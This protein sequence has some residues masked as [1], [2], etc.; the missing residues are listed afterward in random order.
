[1]KSEIPKGLPPRV[2][3]FAEGSRVPIVVQSGLSYRYDDRRMK[4]FRRRYGSFFMKSVAY[5]TDGS[6]RLLL[7][8]DSVSGEWTPPGGFV[9]PNESFEEAAIREIR[10]ETGLSAE[11]VRARR[12][13][14]MIYDSPSSGRVPV[15][16]AVFRG[17]LTRHGKVSPG[18]TEVSQI[19]YFERSQIELLVKEGKAGAYILEDW[20]V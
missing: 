15:Y 18:S 7:V 1:M 13:I 19:S 20:K 6:H 14:T 11:S 3:T 4:S 5:L 10:E 2:R 8:Q 9:E 16:L 12:L 17:R